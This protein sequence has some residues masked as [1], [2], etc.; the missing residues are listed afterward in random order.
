MCFPFLVQIH[1]NRHDIC[2]LIL[3]RSCRKRM[4]TDLG[5]PELYMYG[6][7]DDLTSFSELDNLVDCKMAR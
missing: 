4:H 2:C 5:V 7:D 1:Q 6:E 3:V